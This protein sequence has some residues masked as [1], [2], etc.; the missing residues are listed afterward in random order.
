MA[1]WN[2]GHRQYY[3][4]GGESRGQNHDWHQGSTEMNYG[5]GRGR[6]QGGRGQGRRGRSSQG[7]Q[8]SSNRGHAMG[9]QFL[10]EDE[11][12]TLSQ[13]SPEDVLLW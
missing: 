8:G 7:Y 13:G 12:Q 9:L 5:R 2:G 1:E 11:L 10:S 3:G 4:S 6:R